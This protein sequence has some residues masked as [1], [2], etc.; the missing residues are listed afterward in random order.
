M[1][2]SKGYERMNELA[3]QV[4]RAL[5]E[6]ESGKLDLAGLSDLTE[7]ARALYERLVVLRHKAREVAAHERA[8]GDTDERTSIRLDTRPADTLL[9]QTSLIDAI[10]ETEHLPE[11]P[12]PPN[13]KPARA[14]A[15]NKRSSLADRMEKAP[16]ADLNK[17]I[18]LSQKFWFVA[19]LF[20]GDRERYEKAIATINGMKTADEARAWLD[21]EVLKPRAKP[22][23]KDAWNAFVELVQRRFQ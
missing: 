10:A 2:L 17:A 23:A 15:E 11:A 22:P 12:P 7:D 14:S 5:R 6:L 8:S 4:R 18:T 16:V 3:E 13:T 19:E 20:E 1:S 21:A 9:R